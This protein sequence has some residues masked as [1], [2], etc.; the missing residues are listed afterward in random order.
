MFFSLEFTFYFCQKRSLP[1]YQKFPAIY[2]LQ[3]SY[4]IQFSFEYIM[5]TGGWQCWDFVQILKFGLLLGESLTSIKE[6]MKS[7]EYTY[8]ATLS[9]G[10]INFGKQWQ[11]E[12]PDDFYQQLNHS[13]LLDSIG[14]PVSSYINLIFLKFIASLNN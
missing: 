2:K 14:V 7:E 5:I 11:R 12:L 4:K 1:I 9:I 8:Y 3:S 13:L 10:N 6:S